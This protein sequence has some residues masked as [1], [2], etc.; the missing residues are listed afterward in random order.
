MAIRTASGV[1]GREREL[2]ALGAFVGETGP[3]ALTLEGEPGIGK[4]TLWLAG[5]EEAA[6]RGRRVLRSRP[7]E[8]EAHLAF[9]GLGDLLEDVLDDALG[10]LPPPQAEALRI[11]LLLEPASGASRDERMLGVALLGVLRRLVE[12]QP[13]L[14]A[15][16]DV[17]WLD[18]A[19]AGVLAFAWRRL[20][21]EPVGL[22]LCAG[23]AVACRRGSTS[24]SAS[25]WRP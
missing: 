16:D 11:A 12:E 13:V 25:P 4:T 1:V 14:I 18:A 22:L 23:P 3:T 9:A 2:A 6:R 5:V 21:R 8:A 20:R 7:A 19:T 15:V 17:Q 10:V 24:A